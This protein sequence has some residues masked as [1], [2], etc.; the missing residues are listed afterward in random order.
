M[1]HEG[2]LKWGKERIYF[3]IPM[4]KCNALR[5]LVMTTAHEGKL[6]VAFK[7]LDATKSNQPSINGDTRFVVNF[8]STKDAKTFYE[9]LKQK[10]EYQKLRPDRTMDYHGHQLDNIAHYASGYRETRGALQRIAKAVKNP[11]GTYT[12]KKE[13]GKDP[14]TITESQ[15]NIFM[16]QLRAMPDPKATW[17]RA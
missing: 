7:Y 14:M 17:E 2:K 3:E 16:D 15:Y 8:A 9:L 10:P 1:A 11:D 13:N 4:E 6:P 12:Y 5:N